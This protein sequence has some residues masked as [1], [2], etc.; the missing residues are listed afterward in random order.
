VTQTCRPL[1]KTTHPKFLGLIITRDFTAFIVLSFLAAIT[2]CTPQLMFPLTVQYSPLRHRATMTSV[3]LSGL[4]CGIAC[5]RILSGIVSQFAAWRVVYWIAFGLQLATVLMI[6]LFMP[7]CPVLRPDTSYLG[8]LWT[9]AQLPFRHAVLTQQSLIAFLTMATFTCFW[10]TLTFKLTDKFGFTTL[11]IG[12]F[13]L[14]GLAPVFLNP[15]VARLVTVR[16]HP[17]GTLIIA[18]VVSIVGVCIGTFVGD[19]SLGGLIVRAFLGDLGMNTAVVANR[20]AIANVH[21]KAQNAVNSVYMVFTFCGQMT[22]TAA[23]NKLYAQGGWIPTGIMMICFVCVSFALVLVRG[24]HEKG[25]VGWNGGWDLRVRGVRQSGGE[26][27]V[28]ERRDVK[29]DIEVAVEARPDTGKTV[30]DKQTYAE[31]TIFEKKTDA[32]AKMDAEARMD[33]EAE[34]STES[35]LC[36]ERMDR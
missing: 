26:T 13:S 25:W 29:G 34:R 19:F 6:V 17:S 35:T 23:G 36:D 11:K 2:G 3:L 24:P 7:D 5:A 9:M 1:T 14:I 4:V 21:P 28:E 18:H 10:T 15:V 33:A 27:Q 16:I 20:M 32:E 31:E 8:C 12:L 22:G 30:C